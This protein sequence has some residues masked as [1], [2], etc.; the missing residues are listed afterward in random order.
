MESSRD[1]SSLEK[2]STDNLVNVSPAVNEGN[3]YVI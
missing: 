3:L 1:E 2:S